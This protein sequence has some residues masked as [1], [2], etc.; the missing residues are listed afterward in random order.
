MEVHIPM[1]PRSEAATD[2]AKT[3]PT[4][5]VRQKSL[6]TAGAGHWHPAAGSKQS[7][8]R[9]NERAAYKILEEG[10]PL[11]SSAYQFR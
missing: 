1:P 2:K 6:S 5:E 4:R 7:N 11:I 8:P 9:T 3:T 10:G